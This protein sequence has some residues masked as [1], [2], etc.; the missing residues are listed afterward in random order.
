MNVIF[1][2]DLHLKGSSPISRLDDYP[3]TILN[4]LEY[5]AN[6]INPKRCGTIII[7]G[8]VF[9]SPITSLQYLSQVINTFKNVSEKGFKVYTIVG[10]HDIKNNRMDSL[11][12]TALGI[13]LSTGSIKLAPKELAINNTVFRC[14]NYPDEIEPKKTDSYEVCVAHR[15]Y[16]FGLAGDSLNEDDLKRLNYD[17]MVLGHLHTPCDTRIIGNTTLYMPGSLSRNTSEPYNKLRT[18]RILVFN[19]INHSGTYVN[20]QCKPAEEVFV[21]QVE[22]NNQQGLSMKDLIKFITTS[23]SSADM[24]VRDYFNNLSIPYECREKIVKYLDAIGA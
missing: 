8:D 24:N 5:I 7:L 4:K 19:C 2:G 3:T 9:D 16:D 14:Y 18:P 6:S 11:P 20:V 10:N 15:Y 21:S 1:I 17:A 23:Y 13:L 22:S 12:S